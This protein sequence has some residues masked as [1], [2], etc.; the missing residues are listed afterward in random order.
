MVHGL[1]EM[2][3]AENF[4]TVRT[5]THPFKSQVAS[6][7]TDYLWNIGTEKVEHA[8]TLYM[9]DRRDPKPTSHKLEAA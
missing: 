8:E 5:C 6:A 4:S 2:G 7:P 9:N 3:L 1:S